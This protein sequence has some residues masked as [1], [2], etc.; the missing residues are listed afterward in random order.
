MNL[1]ITGMTCASCVS[2]VEKTLRVLPGIATATV[3]LATET[4]TLTAATPINLASVIA[5]VNK[6]GYGVT[7]QN[8]VLAISGMTCASCVGRVEQAL[9]N[10]P[11][12]LKAT[13]N[14]ATEHA[15]VQIASGAVTTEA[16]IDAVTRAGY[17]ATATG[18]SD[19]P[20]PFTNPA[21][22]VIIA[23]LL[24]FPLMLP[25][26]AAL[27][28]AHWMLPGWLQFLLAT[29]VQFVLGARFYRAGWKALLAR[30][31]P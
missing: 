30:S 15:I 18:A 16:L 27:F 10:L 5:A 19:K 26:L 17:Q 23:A 24:S 25:M 20:T 22:P 6:S 29:P 14:L 12:V 13:V 1:Q 3:N 28:G 4:V 21:L 11:G 2:R 7:E 31:C 8:I 9:S